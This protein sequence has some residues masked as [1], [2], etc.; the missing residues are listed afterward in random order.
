MVER[1]HDVTVYCCSGY[2]PERPSSPLGMRL[3][4]LPAIREKHLE[5]LSRSALSA[6]Q[7]PRHAAIV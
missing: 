3:R 5:T 7:L 2:S 1:G 4:Y 6:L